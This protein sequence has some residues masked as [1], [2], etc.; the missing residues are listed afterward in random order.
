MSL[1]C[2]VFQ[3]FLYCFSAMGCWSVMSSLL[4]QARMIFPNHDY[5]YV[6]F[7]PSSLRQL[8]SCCAFHP[9]KYT[10]PPIGTHHNN[11]E[12]RPTEGCSHAI[13]ARGPISRADR[14]HATQLQ[15]KTIWFVARTRQMQL[16]SVDNK[17]HGHTFISNPLQIGDRYT[18]SVGTRLLKKAIH[19]RTEKGLAC[20]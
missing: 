14:S 7:A 18:C 13:S 17:G 11:C 16:A 2:R 8:T 4:V 5:E 15:R 20:F 9:K 6:R 10:Q 3:S 19:R 12:V 1:S